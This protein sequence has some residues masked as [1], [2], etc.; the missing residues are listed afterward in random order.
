MEVVSTLLL[1]LGIC[2][3]FSLLDK[4][5]KRPFSPTKD[6]AQKPRPTPT[7]YQGNAALKPGVQYGP[8][9]SK[10]EGVLRKPVGD[11]ICGCN[12]V[13]MTHL[14]PYSIDYEA[15]KRCP[16]RNRRKN[17]GSFINDRG[18]RERWVPAP[19]RLTPQG[20]GPMS[21]GVQAGQSFYKR[22]V[23]RRRKR[24]PGQK[25]CVSQTSNLLL[26]LRRQRGG[27]CLHMSVR[28]VR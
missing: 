3:V 21:P 15:Y 7:P 17:T 22:L 26:G 19:G 1:L 27:V 28:T 10:R 23:R 14:A 6:A 11:C 4:W 13:P 24:R 18:V 5:S 9:T 20:Q 8:P 2:W 25:Y 12:G 16:A